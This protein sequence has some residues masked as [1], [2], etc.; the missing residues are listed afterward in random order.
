ML[1]GGLGVRHVVIGYDFYFGKGRAG[2]PE[3]MRA[4]GAARGF[5]VT[6]VAPVAEAGEVFSSSAVRSRLS[7]GDVAGAAHGARPLV[8]GDRAS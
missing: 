2:T 3:T 4:L 7:T 8:A 5:G 6:V 1:V